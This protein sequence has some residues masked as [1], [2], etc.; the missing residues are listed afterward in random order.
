[1]PRHFALVIVLA[2]CAVPPFAA[3][4]AETPSGLIGRFASTPKKV[5]VL[6]GRGK[7]RCSRIADTLSIERTPFGGG[8]DVHVKGEFM[9]PDAR[10][11]SFDGYGAWAPRERSLLATDPGSG[12]E[13]SLT[14]VGRELRSLVVQPNQCDSP[15]AGRNWLEGVVLRKR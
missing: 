4:A 10:M 6:E 2:A 7:P 11:C 12:C 13:L 8:R 14:P 15:C 5:C 1:M 9:L 3:R